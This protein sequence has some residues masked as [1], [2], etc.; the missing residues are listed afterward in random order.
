[1]NE[2]AC[3]TDIAVFNISSYHYGFSPNIEHFLFIIKNLI[4][5]VNNAKGNSTIN[6]SKASEM[7]GR[8]FRMLGEGHFQLRGY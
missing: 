4:F 3:L 5:Q 2:E 7:G 1:M 8:K 6:G